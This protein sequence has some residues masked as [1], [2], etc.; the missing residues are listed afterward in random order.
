MQLFKNNKNT[1]YIGLGSNIGDCLQN[2]KTA[3]SL[4]K[5]YF[6]TDVVMSSV[7]RSEPVEL[8]EQPWFLN[9]VVMINP[10]Q[11][12]LPSQV[13]AILKEIEAEMGREPSVRY[14]PRL[15]DLDLLFYQDWVMESSFL[16]IPHP[17]IVERSFVLYPLLELAPDFKHPKFKKTV[18]EILKEVA[19]KLSFCEKI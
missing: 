16:T 5:K 7:Y 18:T 12:L 13:L 1:I 3:V 17:K 2:L 19:D 8:T 11:M 14:G 4:V 6:E 10:K 15:I 9:Q